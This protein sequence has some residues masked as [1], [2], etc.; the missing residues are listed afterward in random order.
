MTKK[1]VER[2][3]SFCGKKYVGSL[4]SRYDSNKCRQGAFRQRQKNNSITVTK[5]VKD[6][7]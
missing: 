5:A 4:R 2:V 3:C 6:S 1:E 7:E